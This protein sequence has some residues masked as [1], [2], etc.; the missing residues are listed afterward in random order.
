MT[1]EIYNA[2]YEKHGSEVHRDIYRFAEI[3]SLCKGNVLDM[4]CGTGDLADFYKG[5]YDGAD[6]SDVAVKFAN[7]VERKNA[8]FYVIDV[9]KPM[10][11]TGKKYDTVVLAEFLEHIEDDEQVFVNIKKLCKPDARIIISVPNGDRVP[12]ENHLREFT[13]PELRKKLQPLGK[14]RFHLWGGFKNRI[15]V[16]VDMGQ[17]NEALMSLV[18]IVKDEA[19]GLEKCIL[20]TL[21]FVDNVIISVDDKT[22]DGTLKIAER[23]AD[24]VKKHTWRDD[25]G[26]ARNFVQE[27]VNTKWILSLDGHEFV[28]ESPRI[29]EMKDEEVDGLMITMLMEGGDTFITPRVFRSHIVWKHAIHNA[30]HC[31]TTANYTDFIVEHDRKGGQSLASTKERM[32]QVKRTME[33][34][35]KEEL[36]IKDCRIRATFYLARYYRQFGMFRL[37]LKYYKKYLKCGVHKGEM[38][39]V[40]YEA[41]ILANTLG[42]HLLALKYLNNAE[43]LLPNRWEIAKQIGMTYMAFDQWQKAIEYLTDSHKI[44]TGEFSYNPEKRNTAET[45][46]LIGFA[47]FQMKEYARAK[48]SFE[49]AIKN[50]TDEDKIK[51]NKRRIELIDRGLVF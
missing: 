23:Y 2:F 16:S 37:A 30:I 28:K 12:D 29:E 41:G 48:I 38:W 40:S 8:N 32:E 14:V 47:W 42:K 25:F 44:N 43:K 13:V 31:D 21:E 24:V 34:T 27:G 26:W 10:V 15:L 11:E 9:T 20:S 18:M 17:K 1:K 33:K 5:G 46:D 39:L 35:L 19:K 36:K 7:Q 45:W 6:I 22:K 3:A 4:A 49:E 50:E 51:L